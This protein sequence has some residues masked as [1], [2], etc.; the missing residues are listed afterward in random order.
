MVNKGI[1][2]ELYS[3]IEAAEIIGCSVKSIRNY[4]SAGKLKAHKVGG[5]WKIY[6]ED[7]EAFMRGE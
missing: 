3:I 4:I 6:R 5:K 1:N 2:I 7:I